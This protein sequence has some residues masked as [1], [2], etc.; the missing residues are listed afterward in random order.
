MSRIDVQSFIFLD[1]GR[2]FT[3]F[4]CGPSGRGQTWRLRT[5]FTTEKVSGERY[6]SA[7][8]E[9]RPVIGI[10]NKCEKTMPPKRTDG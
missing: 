9:D 1:I 3:R 10:P 6:R 7:V 2:S 8:R 4:V 5:Y